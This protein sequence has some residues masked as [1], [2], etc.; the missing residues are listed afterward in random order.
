MCYVMLQLVQV[1][2]NFITS[3]IAEYFVNFHFTTAVDGAK[4]IFYG[5]KVKY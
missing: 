1:Q 3:Y 4:V 5:V 2:Q